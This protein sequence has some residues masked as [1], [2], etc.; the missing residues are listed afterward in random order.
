MPTMHVS[1]DPLLLIFSKSQ[2]SSAMPS[3]SASVVQ[4]WG[5]DLDRCRCTSM[6]AT[7]HEKEGSRSHQVL[8]HW[9]FNDLVA[10]GLQKPS[11]K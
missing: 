8:K 9:M 4:G 3:Q 10:F 1:R 11:V 5:C 2:I 6:V 7:W